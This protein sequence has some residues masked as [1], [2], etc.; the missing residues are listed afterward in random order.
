MKTQFIRC[1][2]GNLTVPKVTTTMICLEG[3]SCGRSAPL[4][5]QHFIIVL[6]VT[7]L[8]F[9]TIC[10]LL[11][12]AGVGSGLTLWLNSSQ[13]A[14][15]N[16]ASHPTRVFALAASSPAPTFTPTP[17]ATLIPTQT[18]T[19]LPT[20]TSTPTPVPSSPTGTPVPPTDTPV[21]TDTP[22]PPPPATDTPAPAPTPAFAFDVLEFEK[23]PTSHL[24]FDVYIAVVDDGN[25]PLA[26]YRV[27]GQH[28]GGMQ[29]DSEGS[30]DRWT[31]N[32]GAKHYKA[33]NIKY[34]VFNSPGG[35]WTLQLVDQ[36]GQPA[37]PPL[38][39]PFDSA[40]PTWYFVLYQRR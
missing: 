38:E 17:T 31:E 32:S 29:M 26:G 5:R 24:N 35:V 14:G 21:S 3:I 33:G 37:A 8:L 36:A 27:L 10:V 9:L 16:I 6:A 7:S 22:P 20:D 12:L 2:T 15:D 4:K 1:G 13:A 39:F 28:S 30:A 11:S 34:E 25:H 40:S 18:P 19:P 23:F